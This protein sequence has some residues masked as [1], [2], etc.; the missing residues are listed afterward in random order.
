MHEAATAADTDWP[1]VLELYDLLDALAPSPVVTLNRAVAVA[2]V[3]GPRAGLAGLDAL[4]DDRRLAEHH[5]L[6]S[7]RAHLQEMAGDTEA[8]RVDFED[9]ARRTTSIPEQRYL[10]AQAERLRGNVENSP[11]AP[12]TG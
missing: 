5:R 4:A 7:V 2:M 6:V 12:T 1:Q 9:A 8:A 10:Q 11:A 3:D